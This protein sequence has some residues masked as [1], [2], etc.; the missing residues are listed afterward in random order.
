MPLR[1]SAASQGLLFSQ[2]LPARKSRPSTRTDAAGVDQIDG[3]IIPLKQAFVCAMF[4]S[5]IPILIALTCPA[6]SPIS[7]PEA[8]ARNG[9]R[10]VIG[11]AAQPPR[12]SKQQET[13]FLVPRG[14]G[15]S[16]RE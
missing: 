12:Q 16:N 10:F 4:F 15:R 6:A 8:A 14:L 13:P 11:G 7:P 9:R 3:K 1:A 2:A 5:P